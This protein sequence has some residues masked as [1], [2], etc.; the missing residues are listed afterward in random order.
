MDDPEVFPY[1]QQAET[2]WDGLGIIN[3]Q[4]AP[5]FNSNHAESND[6]NKEI[7]YCKEHDLP[8]KALT[9]GEVMIIN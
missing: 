5:H 6:I 8:Y 4:F 7:E 3:W 9:D 1:V 2:I